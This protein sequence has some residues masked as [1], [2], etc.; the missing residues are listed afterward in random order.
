MRRCTSRHFDLIRLFK[1]AVLQSK[2][3][4]YGSRVRVN[5]IQKH[6]TILYF[7]EQSQEEYIDMKRYYNLSR[8]TTISYIS[9]LDFF[10][11]RLRS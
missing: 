9:A 10:S 4:F 7:V 5:C 2:N 1:K 3:C 8:H 11:S 6:Q